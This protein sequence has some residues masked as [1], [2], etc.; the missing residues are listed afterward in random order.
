MLTIEPVAAEGPIGATT[1][2]TIDLAAIA[3][4]WRMLAGLAAPAIAG[5]AVKGDAYG[6]GAARVAPALYGSGC[7]HFFVAHVGEGIAL[8]P[9]LPADAV[10]FVLHGIPAGTAGEFLAH[11][12]T[13]VL[14]GLGDI[15]AWSRAGAIA[16][17]R[18]PAALHVD[19]G[20]S[21]L[22]LSGAEVDL[23]CAEPDR[24]DGISL[25]LVISHLACA[26][27]P[28]NPMTAAQRLRFLDICGRLPHTGRP[29]RR[30]LANSA[31]IFWGADYA[32]DLVRPGIALY[33]GNPVNGR[34]APVRPVVRLEAGILQVREIDPPET[35]GYGATHKVVRPTRVATVAVGYADGFLRAAGNRALAL[36]DGRE[37]P[38][39]GRISMDLMTIDVTDVAPQSCRP[40]MYITLVGDA[41]TI[42]RVAA[43]MD[44]VSYELLTRLG[45]RF[46][47]VY[48]GGAA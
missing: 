24:L 20:M 14:N 47:R 9:H 18:L 5:A 28:A 21:R 45:R 37:V 17:R 15:A 23:L 42:D 29:F 34:L 26:D 36:V 30:A 39:L 44:T 12:L 3:A 6:L 25:D 8:R 1:R 27:D 19:T 41:L 31:G 4:N 13:P 32:F 35:V 16:H 48:T 2:L 10:I 7:R 46:E 38:V 11:G 22:G 40:G 43:T 33:G